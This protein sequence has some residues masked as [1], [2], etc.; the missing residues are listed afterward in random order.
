MIYTPVCRATLAG[1]A[2][3]QSVFAPNIH[4]ADKRPLP[5]SPPRALR[6]DEADREAILADHAFILTTV[7]VRDAQAF[8]AYLAALAGPHARLGGTMLVRGTAREMR[9]RDGDAGEGVR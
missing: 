1:G 9:E 4:P 8:A 2:A 7:E 3:A 5:A 6:Q